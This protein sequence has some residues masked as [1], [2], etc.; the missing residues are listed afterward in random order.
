M[1]PVGSMPFRQS[2]ISLFPSALPLPSSPRMNPKGG[3]FLVIFLP[4]YKH[5]LE[6]VPKMQAIPLRFPHNYRAAPKRSLA[7]SISEVQKSSCRGRYNR[8]QADLPMH[9]APKK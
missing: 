8:L 3:I 4:S 5:E 6:P 1:I 7:I 2:E 9:P